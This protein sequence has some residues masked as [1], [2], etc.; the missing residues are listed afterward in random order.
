MDGSHCCVDCGAT[1]QED[2]HDLCPAC[3]GSDH[4]TG[5]VGEP[6]H[7]LQLFA[8]CFGVGSVGTVVPS[9][10]QWLPTLSGGPAKVLE[11]PE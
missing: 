7:G 6:L 2:G 11:A 9:E 3:L 5:P 10:C 4:L 1:L 8:L